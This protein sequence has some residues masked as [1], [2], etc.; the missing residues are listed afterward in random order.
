MAIV[1]ILDPGAAAVHKVLSHLQL[2]LVFAPTVAQFW[3]ILEQLQPD[4]AICDISS[5]D[6]SGRAIAEKCRTVSP[7]TSVLFTGPPICRLRASARRIPDKGYGG[8]P[9]PLVGDAKNVT[10]TSG[11]YN[12]PA[13][14]A[15]MAGWRT[16]SGSDG[17]G[18][19]MDVLMAMREGYTPKLKLRDRAPLVGWPTPRANDGTGDKIPPGRQGG[20]ALKTVAGWLTPRVDE[21]ASDRKRN[22]KPN[23]QGL[24]RLA[25]GT[26]Q[27]GSPVQTERRGALNPALSLWLMGYPD[28]WLSCGV[29]AMQSSRRS[30]QPS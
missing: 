5:G 13:R 20:V 16:P 8:W 27:S 19:T 24:A 6:V 17:E 25:S 18:G 2:T 4:V 1:V 28:E 29:R 14:T 10:R 9:T 7:A 12:S 22:G 21:S 15:T 3:S 11:S 30:R 26:M 23:R